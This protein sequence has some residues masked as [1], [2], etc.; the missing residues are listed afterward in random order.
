VR[1]WDLSLGK[2]RCFRTLAFQEKGGVN[3]LAF[4][5]EG[6]WLAAVAGK[7]LKVWNA[8]TYQVVRTIPGEPGFYCVAFSPDEKQVAAAGDSNFRMRFP[9]RVWDVATD[10]E[11]RV[12]YGNS[13]AVFQV[14][15]SPDGRHL[16]S[17]GMDGTPRI[18]DT[19]TDK[20]IDTPPLTP[21]C[22]SLGLAFSPDGQQLALGSNDQV[23]RVW[24]TTDWK[25][26]HEYRDP[27]GVL[28]VAFSPD[29]KRLAWGSTDST[30]KI[31]DIS[32]GRA[33][34]VSP[35]VHTLR[36]HTSWVLSVAFSPDSK[37]I[38][39]AS[40]DGTVKIWKAPPVAE[41]VG[42]EARNQDP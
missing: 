2:P 19:K 1:V 33:G 17:A 3:A 34:G 18:W 10:K 32:A 4:S 29:G 8:T 25:L 20:R 16:A 13:W 9:V 7:E 22:P 37:H 35:P 30:V 23:V 36:G 31:W 5:R 39:S 15:F 41:P 40:A 28:S 38:A 42:A 11:P 12:V 21:A 27:G 6:Q 26:R 14:A 24:D